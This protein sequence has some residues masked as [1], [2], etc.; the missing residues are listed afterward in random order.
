LQPGFLFLSLAVVVPVIIHL[1]YIQQG[2]VLKVGSVALLTKD[3]TK[4][5]SSIKL[6]D[7]LLL[8]LRCLLILLL[9]VLLSQPQWTGNTRKEKG[10]VLI[11]KGDVAQTYAR[12]KPTVDSLLQGGYAL[13]YFNKGFEK[14]DLPTALAA[15]KDTAQPG[16]YWGTLKQLTNNAGTQM[17]LY[18]FTN[19]YAANFAGDRPAAL[20][21]IHWY[22]YTPADTSTYTAA[23]YAI[24][25]DSAMVVTANSSATATYNTYADV[26]TAQLQTTAVDTAALRIVI[27]SKGYATDAGYIKAAIDAIQ[28][29]SKRKII[30]SAINNVAQIPAQQDWLFWLANEPV[31]AV[32]RNKNLFIYEKGREEKTASWVAGNEGQIST[33]TPTPLFKSI[34]APADD[35]T[36]VVWRD[37]FGK[38]LL[39]KETGTNIVYHFFSRF[40]AS[41]SDLVWSNDFPKMMYSLLFNTSNVPSVKDKRVIDNSQLQPF[42]DKEG[43]ATA[44]QA[45]ASTDVSGIF[46]LLVFIIFFI[47]RIIS[48]RV[49][50]ERVY[51]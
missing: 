31:P 42:V 34:A 47:E 15:K 16:N 28:Q 27:Y 39:T 40:D 19:N 33:S 26:A 20:P 2:K 43:A 3:I 45:G 13:H 21:N 46:W 32:M 44:K 8:F 18:I 1:W 38:A 50:K 48:S 14:T 22:S 7:L 25:G 11:D 23:A 9:A 29:F 6:H 17:P 30:T 10:W 4:T 51:A 36:Q 12:F 41:W 24:E 49:K 5:S 35:N 37:G